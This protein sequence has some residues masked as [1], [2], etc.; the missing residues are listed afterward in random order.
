M[1]IC[2][3]HSYLGEGFFVKISADDCGICIFTSCRGLD[4]SSRAV[5]IRN[6]VL[7]IWIGGS[8]STI[9]DAMDFP[10]LSTRSLAVSTLAGYVVT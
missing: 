6:W 5:V 3:R 2:N 7:E 9:S 4:E 1:A 8:D 10:Y